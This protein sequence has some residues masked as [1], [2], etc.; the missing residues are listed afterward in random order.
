M[1]LLT[2][3]R[4]RHSDREFSHRVL[5]LQ[6]LSDLLWAAFGINRQETGGRTA[7]SARNWQEIDLYV[8]LTNGLYCYCPAENGLT[9]VIPEDIRALTGLQEFVASAPVNLLYV[10][11][12]TRVAASDDDER[13]FYCAANAG[14]IAQ[15]VYLFCASEGLATVVRGLINRDELVDAIGLLPDQRIVLAQTIGYPAA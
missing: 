4:Q 13:R 10:A 7:P 12:L 5:S 2:A 15:N 6:T 8:A 14:F 11:D 9:P 3:L 1:P